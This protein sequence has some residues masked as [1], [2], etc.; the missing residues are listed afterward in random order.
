MSVLVTTRI[1]DLPGDAYDQIAA[2][3]A[4]PL[5]AADGFIAHAAS[6]S[7]DG[8]TVTELWEA[9]ADWQRFFEANV[10]PN[11]PAGLPAPT[12]TEVR[13]TILA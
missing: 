11:L 1:P 6:S 9:R 2:Q 5:R 3:L 7:R 13:N 10:E 4:E 8:V 12:I